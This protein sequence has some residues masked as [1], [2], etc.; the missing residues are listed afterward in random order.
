M[1][2]VTGMAWRTMPLR[3]RLRLIAAGFLALGLASA[4][5]IRLTAEDVE[6]SPLVGQIYSSKTYL[7]DM[8]M[9]G[10]NAAVFAD[11]FDRWFAGL[12]RGR[13]LAWTVACITI[14]VV[15]GLCLL[16]HHVPA[17][18]RPNA[19]VDPPPEGSA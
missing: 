9:I 8:R 17:E 7:R 4:L 12:W 19:R 13:T 5:V 18:P 16:A 11:E 3:T 10:G 1:G 6:D 14:A 15:G 2:F